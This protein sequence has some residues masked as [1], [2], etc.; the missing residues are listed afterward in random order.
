M[1]AETIKIKTPI[2]Y[3]GGKQ[4][5]VKVL[6]EMIPKHRIYC[7]PF[8]GGGALFFQKKPSYLE[9]INDINDNL[10][11]FYLQCQNNFEELAAE[12]HKTLCSESQYIWAQEIY[13]GQKVVDDITKAVATW[14][15]FQCGFMNSADK[16]WKWDN[17]TDNSHCGRVLMHNRKNFCPWIQKRLESVQISCMDA[18]K[19]IEQRDTPG[20]FFYLDPP[21]PNSDQGHY[22]GYTIDNLIELL[23]LLETIHGQFLLSCYELPV[24]HEYAEKKNWQLKRIEMRKRCV[25]RYRVEN[26]VECLLYNF[27]ESKPIQ[28]E[29]F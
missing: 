20:S 15:V 6:L 13:Q 16:S 19:V 21:Y 5:L 4:Q 14:I 23:Q 24:L 9:V 11:N 25:S 28:T 26:K 22:K 12:I 17:G 18:L 2:S 8:F 29:L 1:K 7:E 27:K 3:Y 10:I